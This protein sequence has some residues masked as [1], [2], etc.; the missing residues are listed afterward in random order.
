MNKSEL[1]ELVAQ[2]TGIS[3]K[4]AEHAVN[5]TFETMAAELIAGRKVQI[6]GFGIF[7]AKVRK[8]RV[9]RNPHTKEPIQIPASNTPTFKA[10]KVLK[11]MVAK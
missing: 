9:G 2:K 3:K 6:S 5:A 1:I 10:S 4:D 7:E 8:A 11:D